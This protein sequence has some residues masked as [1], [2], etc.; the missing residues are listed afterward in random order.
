MRVRGGLDGRGQSA[1]AS[2]KTSRLPLR[3]SYGPDNWIPPIITTGVGKGLA[4]S[5]KPWLVVG[6]GRQTSLRPR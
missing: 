5:P 2:P 4:C 3:G 1:K 6:E